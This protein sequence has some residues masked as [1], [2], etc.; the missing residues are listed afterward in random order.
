LNTTE[1]NDH[2]KGTRWCKLEKE[3]KDF[4]NRGGTRTRSTTNGE[5]T[6]VGRED[7]IDLDD[8]LSKGPA[9]EGEK[10]SYLSD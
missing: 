8:R 5:K 2:V 6:K 7:P 10:N 1:V 3:R 9:S 4:H